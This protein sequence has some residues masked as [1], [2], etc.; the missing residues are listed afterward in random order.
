MYQFSCWTSLCHF[1]LYRSIK[2]NI[3]IFLHLLTWY[4]LL[5][6]QK[7]SMLQ[8]LWSFYRMNYNFILTLTLN[9]W[10]TLYEWKWYSVFNRVKMTSPQS[11][12]FQIHDWT[13]LLNFRWTGS[14]PFW[15]NKLEK[16]SLL[17][18][19]NIISVFINRHFFEGIGL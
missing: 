11:V 17:Y 8:D 12:M 19:G 9:Y 6:P 16:I 14:M 5:I 10:W 18:N 13:T 4:G 15:Q 3:R 7:V 2:N 1:Y